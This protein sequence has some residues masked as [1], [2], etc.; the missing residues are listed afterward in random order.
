[1][2]RPGSGRFA[3]DSLAVEAHREFMNVFVR[4]CQ[5]S[6]K[7]TLLIKGYANRTPQKCNVLLLLCIST[8]FLRC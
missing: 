7:S 3:L 5:N 2:R 1:V 4:Q 8:D 6:G